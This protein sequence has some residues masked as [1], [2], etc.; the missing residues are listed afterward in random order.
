MPREAF[1]VWLKISLFPFTCPKCVDAVSFI[2]RIGI[3]SSSDIALA[4]KNKR[5]NIYEGG[6]VYEW[7]IFEC[8]IIASQFMN[9]YK[10]RLGIKV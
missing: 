6:G 4:Y 7:G 3:S 10:K 5:L 8:W 2:A 9:I 1:S